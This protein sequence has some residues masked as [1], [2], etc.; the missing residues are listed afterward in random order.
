MPST[1]G[2]FNMDN[3][4]I[5]KKLNYDV[6]VAANFSDTSVWPAE[7][8]DR[9]REELAHLDVEPIHIDFSRN[10]VNILSH[11]TAY[12]SLKRLV[13]ERRYAFVHTHTPVASAIA[14]LVAIHTK[15]K[16]IYTAHGFHFYNGAPIKNWLL[17][18]PIEKFLSSYTYCL[19]TINKEDYYRA[20]NRFT[21]ENTVY[22]PGVGVDQNAFKR[23][24]SAREKIRNELG[25]SD[26]QIM[27]LSVGELNKNK[28]HEAVIKALAELKIDII[29]TVVGKGPLDTYLTKLAEEKRVKIRLTGFRKNVADYYSAADIYIL[30]SIREGLNVSLMEAMSCELPCCASRIRGNVD[31]ITNEHCLF[32]PFSS[33]E[34]AQSIKFVIA[35]H[36]KCS[37]DNSETIGKFDKES[38][39]NHMRKIYKSLVG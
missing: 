38:V 17:F 8:I 24:N 35:S 13:Q 39:R 21:A 32:S 19:V 9:F 2:Q 15:T 16:V 22:I 18:Y 23:S 27:L 25:I 34:I 10:P 28:N 14:R 26:N 6:D 1:I 33:E 37:Q 36:D 29:Y 11:V 31:L 12:K 20:Y 3:I 7:R 5:L 30:P 4:H